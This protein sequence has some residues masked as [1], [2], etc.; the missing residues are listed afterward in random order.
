MAFSQWEIRDATG[1][2]I[3][4]PTEAIC[5]RVCLDSRRVQP[6]DLFV[7]I[8][9]ERFDGHAFVADAVSSGAAAVLV[10]RPVPIPPGT[11]AV[12]VGDTVRALGA[13]A[14]YHRRRFALPVVAVTGST[15]KTTVK[16]M[17]ASLGAVRHRVAKTVGNRNNEIGL[18]LTLLELAPGDELLV[19][20]MG[21]RGPGQIA[22]L[23]A[24]A[25]PQIGVVTNIGL[26]HLEL[27]GTR[28][29][30]AEAK[31]ELPAA[32]PR[33]GTAVLNADDPF[34][35]RLA[36]RT[37]A[38]VLGFG[39]SDDAAVRAEDVRTDGEG[40]V[41][42][43][44]GPGWPRFTIRLRVPGEHQV[45]NALAA[46]AV[47]H[48]LGYAPDEIRAGLEN[49]AVEPGRGAVVAAR[50]GWA[51]IDDTYNASPAS[52]LAALEVLRRRPAAGRRLAVLGDMLE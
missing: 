9:G 33:E 34:F 37:R 40:S 23:A 20:E 41:V 16:E 14:R 24:V 30:I 11:G 32:L 50:E 52:V 3:M 27:L 26:T 15:G 22:A 13:L 49:F 6:G 25:E 28:E 48:A 8:P 36:E 18:P 45:L 4:A 17:I 19:V 7:A 51:V 35:P 31:G 21:M 2:E 5:G 10:S 43:V 42:A 39:L 44:R 38:R 1:G 12:L 29:A 47:G 46:A